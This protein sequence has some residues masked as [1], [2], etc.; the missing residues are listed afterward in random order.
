[1]KLSTFDFALPEELVAQEPV[2]P[3]D[4]SRLLVLPALRQAEDG[5]SPAAAPEHRTFTDLPELLAPG[6][7]LVLNDTRVIPA[8]IEGRKESGGKVELLLVEPLEPGLGLG[9]GWRAM[10]QASKPIRAGSVLDFGAL[11]ARVEEVEGEGFYRVRLDREGAALEAALAAVGRVPLPPYIRRAPSE[12][13]R[14][15]YQTVLARAP[16]SAAAPTAGLHFT[17]RLFARLAARGIERTTV[18]L[19]VGPGTFLPVRTD[20]L[21]THRM[22]GERFEVSEHAA[23]AVAACRARGGRVVAVGTT[24]VRTLEAAWTGARLG[25]GPGR[26]TLFIRPGFQFG[27][28][29]ALVTNFHLPRST[30][31]VLACAFGGTDRVLAAYG[32]AVARRYRFFSYGD[33]MLMFR[34]AP[35]A[36]V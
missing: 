11:S 16:G 18:T 13:D 19:H 27:V 7:L 30:L 28:V 15:R 21:D 35:K 8:R 24:S 3:R 22:H 2:S 14:E 4:A 34:A 17:D 20:D 25:V 10:G 36:V 26:T 5:L 29:D 12:A 32:E 33:A 23:A 31:L 6:D 9:T 1:M